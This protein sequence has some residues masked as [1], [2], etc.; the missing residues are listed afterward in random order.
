MRAQ[1]Q[2]CLPVETIGSII[3]GLNRKLVNGRQNIE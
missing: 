2:Q 1:A 3:I